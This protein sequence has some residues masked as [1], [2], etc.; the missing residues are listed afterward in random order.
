LDFLGYNYGYNITLT[1]PSVQA[2]YHY[3]GIEI[4]KLDLYTGF[5]I[6]FSIVSVSWEDDL[7]GS[8]DEIVGTSGLHFSSFAGIRYY[9]SPKMALTAAV[10]YS[11]VGDWSGIN[12]LLGVSFK[13]K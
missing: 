2:V 3:T 4:E 5:N 9:L 11:A 13:L 12:A 1:T 6:G 8:D 7:G 10:N